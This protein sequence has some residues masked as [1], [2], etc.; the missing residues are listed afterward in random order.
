MI[1]IT[2]PEDPRLNRWT[3]DRRSVEDV[4]ADILEAP[5]RLAALLQ[6]IQE[7]TMIGDREQ[8]FKRALEIL[9]ECE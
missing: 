6:A 2:D 3:E 1:P 7:K 5:K 4:E 9:E 8:I